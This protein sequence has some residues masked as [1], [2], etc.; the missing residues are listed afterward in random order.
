MANQQ[1][2]FAHTGVVINLCAE[3]RCPHSERMASAGTIEG[4]L[5]YWALAVKQP[6]ARARVHE[7][8]LRGLGDWLFRPS[9]HLRDA[10]A[11]F[12][13]HLTAVAASSQVISCRPCAAITYRA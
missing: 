12:G 4:S 2:L 3:P 9:G 8:E 5:A 13:R 1:P 7:V 6:G 10:V 11:C